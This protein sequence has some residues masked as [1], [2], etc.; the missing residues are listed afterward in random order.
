MKKTIRFKGFVLLA[1]AAVAISAC[2]PG[3]QKNAQSQEASNEHNAPDASAPAFGNE[4]LAAAYQHY[5]HVKDALVASDQNEAATAAAALKAALQEVPE[6]GEVTQ[7][8]ASVAEAQDVAAQRAAFSELSN[9]MTELVK[10]SDIT[11]GAVYLAFCPMA[12]NDAG[13][14]WLASEQEIR[15]PYFGEKMMKCGEVKETIR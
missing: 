15:N 6:A 14:Y 11:S 3:Q 5:I 8:A 12:N 4:Q 10:T 1:A 2:G 7:A 9:R 13:A